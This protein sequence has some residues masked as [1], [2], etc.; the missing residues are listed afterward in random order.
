MPEISIIVPVYKVEGYLKK[1]IESICN[2]TIKN[3]EI[4]LVDDGSP[5]QCGE[6]CDYYSKRDSRIK[7][8]HK[9]NG[10]LSDARNAGLEIAIGKY[11]GFVDSD[12]FVSSDM[13]ELLF[14]LCEKNNTLIAGCDL[15]YVYDGT[16]RVDYCSNAQKYIMTS[17]EFF[18]LMLD[19][20]KNVRTG[21]WNK[22]YKRELFNNVRFPKG[23]F[24]ED[25]GT[26]Y[27]LIFQADMISYVSIP[28]YHYLKQREG[29]ITNGKY[30]KKEYDRLEM[31]EN[32]VQYIRKYQPQLQNAA[33]AFRAVNCH[34]TIINTMITSK[35]KDEKMIRIIKTDLRNH[36]FQ[37]IRSHISKIKKMQL[38]LLLINYDLYKY[39]YLNQ[40]KGSRGTDSW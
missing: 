10:G 31:S 18:E 28:G 14:D 5:D 40:K 32:M 24:F 33:I 3:I 22:L 2:Q 15:A 8:I 21:V 34:L 20:Q 6:I 9:E 25:V 38:L 27:K 36:Y 39:L 23:K 1:C 7:V 30:S 35:I 29:A 13:F 26:M 17:S 19:V 11:I 37:I 12:D 4:I 16:D